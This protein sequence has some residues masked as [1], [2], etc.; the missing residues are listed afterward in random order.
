MNPYFELHKEFRAGGARV[1]LSSGQACVLFGIAAFSKDGD[2]IIEESGKSCSA[3]LRVLAS[4]Q[5]R[6]R[7]GMPLDIRWLR[8]GWTSHFEYFLDS[9][10]RMRVDF[11]SRPPRVPDIGRLWDLASM[12][13]NIEVVDVDDLV[14]L[15]KT[16]RIRDY[17]VIG[18]LAESLGLQMGNAEIALGHLQ[19]YEHLKKAVARWPREAS[20]SQRAAVKLLHSGAPRRDVVIALALEQDEHIRED[21]RRV[22]RLMKTSLPLRKSFSALSDRWRREETALLAQHR[23]LVE[24]ALPFVDQTDDA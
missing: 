18:A 4:K 23:D 22:E 20:E 5:A 7:L 11:V 12:V 21:E 10:F 2:W 6:Y 19:D 1:L 15:K 24:A 17:S 13:R 8:R 14:R 3:A 16:R 9:G